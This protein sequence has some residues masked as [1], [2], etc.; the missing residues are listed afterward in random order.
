VAIFLRVLLD[1]VR[2]HQAGTLF[3]LAALFVVLGGVLFSVTQHLPVTTGLYW[4]V[5]TAT[6]VGYGD[7][8]PHNASGRIVAVGE[9]LTAIP[10][11]GAAFALL[12]AVATAARSR[13]CA[14]TRP[15]RTCCAAASPSRPVARS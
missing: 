13:S 9:M 15:A 1:R 7:V 11:F 12:A 5:I 14:G 2:R 4:A 3:G 6:T 8:T 10:V